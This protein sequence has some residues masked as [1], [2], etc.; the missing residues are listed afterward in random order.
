MKVL[1]PRFLKDFWK[2]TLVAPPPNFRQPQG[3]AV[4]VRTEF[5]ET[6]RT[7]EEGNGLLV[8]STHPCN[9]MLP[10]HPLMNKDWTGKR[11]TWLSPAHSLPHKADN[12]RTYKTDPLASFDNHAHKVGRFH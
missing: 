9:A 3:E 11:L 6:E 10:H 5:L 1:W 12:L 4:S 7:A 8:T 2:R